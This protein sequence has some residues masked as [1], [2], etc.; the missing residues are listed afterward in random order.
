M[1]DFLGW[2][3]M[4]MVAG[5]V[6]CSVALALDKPQPFAEALCALGRRLS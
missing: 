3:F 5:A 6:Q 1:R 2:C 4:G